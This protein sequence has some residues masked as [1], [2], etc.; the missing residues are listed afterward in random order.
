MAQIKDKWHSCN[1][2][3]VKH[4]C[5]FASA[6]KRYNARCQNKAWKTLKVQFKSVG[7]LMQ[8]KD[9]MTMQSLKNIESDTDWR[10]GLVGDICTIVIIKY[11]VARRI[12]K[13]NFDRLL[14]NYKHL[15]QSSSIYNPFYINCKKWLHSIFDWLRPMKVVIWLYVGVLEK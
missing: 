12:S 11:S 9:P 2:N 14:Q 15:I 5:W 10:V 3:H 8:L 7:L 6:A 4:S 1:L 13:H